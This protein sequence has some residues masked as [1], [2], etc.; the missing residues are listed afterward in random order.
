[1]K[2]NPGALYGDTQFNNE[3]LVTGIVQPFQNDPQLGNL[4]TP[5]NSSQLTLTWVRNLPIYR[6]GLSPIARGLEIGMAHGYLLLGPFLKLGPLRDTDQALLAGA[7]SASGLVVIL[8]ICLFVYG[9]AVFQSSGKPVGV[10]PENLQTYRDWSLFTSGFL[11]GGIG[12][13][14]FACFIL[15]EIGRTGIV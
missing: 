7:S 1:M 10:L 4:A 2:F 14:I 15:L 11:I 3:S 13:V 9:I 8:S 12:G 5:I 6:K